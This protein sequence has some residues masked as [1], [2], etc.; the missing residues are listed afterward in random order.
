MK[1]N[2]KLKIYYFNLFARK[3]FFKNNLNHYLKYLV[4]FCR[5]Y[6]KILN[7][8][9]FKKL[10]KIIL[11]ILKFKFNHIKSSFILFF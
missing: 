8:T 6:N 3:N 2:Y 1:K 10:K 4:I 11:I 5:L 9:G 7:M